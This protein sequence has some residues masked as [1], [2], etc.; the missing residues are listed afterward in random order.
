MK[1]QQYNPSPLERSIAQAIVALQNDIQNQLPG[2]K[3][4]G[5]KTVMETDNPMVHF[6]LE[7]AEGDYH[8]VV[9]RVIQRIDD[10]EEA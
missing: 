8:E 6:Q 7:D 4:T 1:T 9:I 5:S 2:I 10:P 3:I